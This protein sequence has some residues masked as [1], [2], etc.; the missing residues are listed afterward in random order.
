LRGEIKHELRGS[1]VFTCV[2]AVRCG[3]KLPLW[4][5]TV[6]AFRVRTGAR[7]LSLVTCMYGVLIWP[8]KSAGGRF[9]TRGKYHWLVADKPDEQGGPGPPGAAALMPAFCAL[10][11]CSRLS[12]HRLAAGDCSE[13]YS[14]EPTARK[15]RAPAPAD[16]GGH[17]ARVHHLGRS[18]H[19]GPFRF[20]SA[21]KSPGGAP[22]TPKAHV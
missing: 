13:A 7:P 16:H 5:C 12:P 17:W 10:L 3:A 8:A 4:W 20:S 21:Q 11:P 22:P 9:V 6:A 18:R 1:R 19:P 14:H 15:G 2:R